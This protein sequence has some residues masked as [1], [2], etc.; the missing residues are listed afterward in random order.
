MR[1]VKREWRDES[2]NGGYQD[3]ECFDLDSMYPDQPIAYTVEGGR[4]I[5]LATNRTSWTREQAEGVRWSLQLLL[6]KDGS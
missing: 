1:I 2:G 5:E 4:E 6:D 3:F